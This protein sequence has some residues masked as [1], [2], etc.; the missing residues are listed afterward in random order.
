MNPGLCTLQDGIV[1]DVPV[2][3]DPVALPAEPDWDDPEIDIGCEPPVQPDLVLAATPA[4]LE[5]RVV[6][7][8]VV[9]GTLELPDFPVG[10]EDPGD[11]GRDLRHARGSRGGVGLRASEVVEE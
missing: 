4:L 3:T 2:R 5:R 10:E 8:P 11:V 1:D 7:E 6:D 9:D